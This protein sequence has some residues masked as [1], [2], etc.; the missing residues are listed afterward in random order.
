MAGP[1]RVCIVVDR[2]FGERLAELARGVP[3]WIVDTPS[4]KAVAQRLWK[5][6]PNESH[7]TGITTFD[8]TESSS[9]DEL[10][11]AELDSIDLHHGVHSATTPYTELEVLGARLTDTAQAGARWVWIF[12]I[13]RKL[14]R[15]HRNPLR[16]SDLIGYLAFD[17]LWSVLFRHRSLLTHLPSSSV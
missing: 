5:E 1:Y 12:E 2:N 8:D 17:P 14:D 10:L 15:I 7:L 3:V 16:T 11:I 4:N 13:P 6:R 9:A